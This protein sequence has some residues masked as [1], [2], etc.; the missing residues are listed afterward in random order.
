MS[1]LYEL[2]E[3]VINL[4]VATARL[5]ERVAGL[6]TT[7]SVLQDRLEPLIGAV[8]NGKGYMAGIA[9]AGAA[10]GGGISKLFSYFTDRG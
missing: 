9:I 10:I 6:T 3:Q 2:R 8:N 4:T 1:E 5:E 7:V